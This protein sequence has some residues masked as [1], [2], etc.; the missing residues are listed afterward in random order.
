MHIVLIN[1][2]RL[3]SV[4]SIHNP[5]P[6]K[7]IQKNQQP[8]PLMIY[9]VKKFNSSAVELY[10]ENIEKTELVQRPL[11]KRNTSGI[12]MDFVMDVARSGKCV[13]DYRL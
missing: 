4:T 3:V 7:Y 6:Y 11:L 8:Q 9:T 5:N 2:S 13:G 1:F 12:F 10:S